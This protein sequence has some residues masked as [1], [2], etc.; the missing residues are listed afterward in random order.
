MKIVIWVGEDKEI[1][2]YCLATKGNPLPDTIPKDIVDN[3]VSQGLAKIT[4]LKSTIK[5]EI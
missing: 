3:Y 1:P 5:E 4:V 2:G